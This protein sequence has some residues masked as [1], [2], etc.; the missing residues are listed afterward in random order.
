MFRAGHLLWVVKYKLWDNVL[1]AGKG[2]TKSQPFLSLH[3]QTKN[4]Y[5]KGSL[6]VGNELKR[7]LYF[8]PCTVIIDFSLS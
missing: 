6:P 2:T 4:I 7:A 3:G 8:I 5:E 1:Q